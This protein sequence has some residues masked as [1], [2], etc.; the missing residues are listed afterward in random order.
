MNTNAPLSDLLKNIA[1]KGQ[2]A[3]RDAQDE[4]ARADLLSATRALITTLESP[5][6]KICRMCYLEESSRSIL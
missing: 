3:T 1:D 4:K 5:V 2:I 6:E